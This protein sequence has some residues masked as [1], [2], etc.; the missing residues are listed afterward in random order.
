MRV[1]GL[2]GGIASGKSYVAEAL[3]A[4]GAHIVDTDLLARELVQP[5]S[6]ALALIV[7][8]FGTSVLEA[9]GALHRRALRERI[10]GNPAE[11]TALE[12]ILHPR[13]RALAAKL[14][15]SAQAL[16]PAPP[17][18]LVVIP[19]LQEKAS[20]VFLHEVLVVDCHPKTQRLRLM[21][22][23]QV[24]EGLAQQ[25]IAAQLDRFSRLA[26]ADHVVLNDD[27]ALSASGLGLP[28]LCT[29]LD[30]LHQRLAQ[31]FAADQ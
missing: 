27:F 22:R 20:Y 5:G 19:L 14:V 23:D 7:E 12:A 30:L 29:V 13:I 25:M 15:Q 16:A 11:R 4:R 8:H 1:V 18:V 6:E 21:Q 17:Y 24:T 28:K 3:A 26:L 9:N 2:T 10:F 31:S